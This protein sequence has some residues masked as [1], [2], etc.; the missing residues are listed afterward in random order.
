VA[1]SGD[2]GYLRHMLKTFI[3]AAAISALAGPGLACDSA[4]LFA[5]LDAPLPATPDATFDVA[6]MDSAEGG[7]WAVWL[8]PD[9]TTAR[10]LLRTDFGEGGRFATRLVVTSPDAYAVTTT[11][12]I[13]SAPIHVAGSTTIR[14]EKNIYLFC[15]GKLYEPGE[16][17]D[18]GPEYGQSALD[19]L[20]TFDAAEVARYVPAIKRP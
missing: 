13:Y 15:A 6:E 12:F 14:E 1:I 7:N 2:F 9:G 3:C 10:N 19:A 18:L 11:L 5:L 17:F 8:G 16:D 4:Q 20:A